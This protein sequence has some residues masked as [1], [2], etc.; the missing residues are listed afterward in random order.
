MKTKLSLF[1]DKIIEAGWLAAIVTVPLFF[2]IYTARTFE[3]DKITLLRMIA[4]IM[5][6]A[7]IV[8]VIEKG[9]T[10]SANN[11]DS[12]PLKERLRNLFKIPLF[13]P[14]LLMVVVYLVSGLLSISPNVSL[15]GSYQRLQGSYSFISYIMVFL[16]MAG[17]LRTREQA[18]RLVTLAILTS[19]PVSLY[20]IVQRFGLDPLPWAGDTTSRVAAHL[21]N[22]IFVSSYIIMVMPLALSRLIESMTAIIEEEDASWGHTV[23]AAVYIFVLAIQ[24]MTVVFSGSRGPLIGIFVAVFIMGLL[25]ILMLRHFDEDQTA[26]SVR[27]VGSGLF[28]VVPLGLMALAGGGIG[29]G[30]GW[31]FEQL[32]VTAGYQFSGI[33]YLGAFFGGILGFMGLYVYMAV[34]RTGWRWLWLS[35]LSTAA[36]GVAMILLLNLRGTPLDPYL[37]IVRRIP[38]VQA[39]RLAQ[40]IESSG[41]TG[42]VRTLIW[43]AS[44]ELVFPHE[45]LGIAGDDLA[46]ADSLNFIRPLIGYGPE[47]MFN[48]FSF[49]YPPRL[50]H[51]EN[52]GSSADRAHNETV[53]SLVITGVLGFL[54]FYFLMI[55]I[56][57]Y[58][59]MW[60]GWAPDKSARMR[61]LASLI[62]TGLIG[63]I[64]AYV[65]DG[66]ELTY[67]PL[68][69]PFGLVIGI[70]IHLF[71]QGIV[72]QK[73]NPD[74]IKFTGGHPLILVGLLGAMVGHFIEV[75][76]VFSIAATYTY[77]WAFAGLLV[78]MSRLEKPA[79]SNVEISQTSA[80]ASNTVNEGDTSRD[81]RRSSRRGRGRAGSESRSSQ[82]GPSR[83]VSHD[84]DEGWEIQ[85]G[86]QGL[87]MAI[88]F[89]VS[90][91]DFITPQ[92]A[93]SFDDQDSMSL[94]WML[95]IT[96]LVGF[97]IAFSGVAIQTNVRT[98]SAHWWRAVALYSFTSLGY[99]FFYILVHRMQFGQRVVVDPN[100]GNSAIDA[101]D[102]LVNG[103]LIFY[104][105]LLLLLAIF[106]SMLSWQQFRRLSFWRAENWWLYPPLV[107]AA[108][109]M[110]WFKNVNVVRAD[111]YLK[112]GERYREQ[113]QWAHA[114]A[115]HELARDIDSDE[116][117]Y[118]LMLALDYQL[119]AQDS[120]LDANQQAYARSQ[121]EQIALTAR[122]INP[123]NPD[124]TG[125][126][127]RYYFTLSQISSDPTERETRMQQAED[128]FHK[129]IALAPSNVIY[130]NL[131]AQVAYVEQDFDTAIERLLVSHEIDDLYRP[132]SVLLGDSYA[133]KGEA[134]KALEAHTLGMQPTPGTRDSDGFYN[135]ADQSVD[136]RLNYYIQAGRVQ[137][138][139]AALQEVSLY[140]FSEPRILEVIGNVYT[141]AG[142]PQQAIP[143]YEQVV[144]LHEASGTNPSAAVLQNLSQIYLSLENFERAETYYERAIEVNPE[145]LESRSAL[146]YIY[147]QQQRFED[148]IQQHLYILQRQP[149]NYNSWQNL[150]V[151]YQESQQW[152]EALNAG[153]Q[154][155]ALAPEEEIPNWEQFVA[156][157][158]HN[159]T[160]ED[161]QTEFE[162]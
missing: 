27:E 42:E 151:L 121:G 145:D 97:A 31:G 162:K 29:L 133:A 33:I 93:L 68:G 80:A 100:Q 161:S 82:S 110:I 70:V 150:A 159:M 94:F 134:D 72:E 6:L 51:V 4:T 55:S 86:A 119:M 19:I 140:M 154:A 12:V 10:G 69:L 142:L 122:S 76:F 137:D 118:Y 74:E 90:A 63:G 41:G 123:Y 44:F 34:T 107:V 58:A 103:L 3:P 28:F 91:F 17:N 155:M 117:F 5:A 53:D 50:A 116:D 39:S 112:E 146:A 85:I 20:G 67:V 95:A 111:I 152:A 15:W 138:I 37:E 49:V 21:G 65:A 77:F 120:R 130:H 105:F 13:L 2:N 127:G 147:A 89:I 30:A 141:R 66:Y 43:D 113:Q 87:A 45:P 8:S 114:I 25:V 157:M 84:G 108:A 132:T 79:S 54:T 26:L 125:N 75:H 96:W 102:I 62:F 131:L 83:R 64:A 88:I 71:V 38:F 57:Y 101:A 160:V 139:I 136:L 56:F 24:A 11:E 158:Q 128:F 61:L 144:A 153:Q 1:C 35:W 81:K 148:G 23:L 14:T 9:M 7:W 115:L 40:I 52:R 32:L 47:S 156:V 36:V 98:F 104:G 18:D 16:F 59:L 22:A 124:N 78:A 149:E 109:T 48:A 106:A 143:Y 46:P 92:F 73:T 129:A 135:F 126:M 99:F 60:L